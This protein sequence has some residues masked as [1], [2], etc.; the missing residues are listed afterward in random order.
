MSGYCILTPIAW[1]RSAVYRNRGRELP[2]MF[3]P[4][5]VSDLFKERSSPWSRI[6]AKHMKAVCRAASVFLEQLINHIADLTT[7]QNI[8]DSLVVPKLEDIFEALTNKSTGLLRPLQTGHPI[9]YNHYLTE[10]LQKLRDEREAR[11]ID[12]IINETFIEASAGRVVT[13]NVGCTSRDSGIA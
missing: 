4:M 6:A 11:R 1:L 5:I 13:L 12:N 2:G 8:L 10:M 3:N 7:V 9:T